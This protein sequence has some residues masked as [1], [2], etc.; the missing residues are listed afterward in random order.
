MPAGYPEQIVTLGD[1]LRAVRLKRGQHQKHV[2]EFIGVTV[3][4]TLNWEQNYSS[5]TTA[6][7]PKI[8][9]Y[10]GYCPVTEESWGATLGV[11]T[12]LHRIHR[13][14]SIKEAAVE[15]GVDPTSLARWERQGYDPSRKY[16]KL[17][18]RFIGSTSQNHV[19]AKGIGDESP[20]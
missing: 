13:G 4:T 7:F 12:R 9:E 18:R 5:P 2:A 1:H 3:E 16:R 6:C 10:L 8:I 14:L 15:I 19:Q 11:R 20:F 17:L